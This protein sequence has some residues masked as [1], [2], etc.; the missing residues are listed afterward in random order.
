[1]S[2]WEGGGGGGWK[3]ELNLSLPQGMPKL[4]TSRCGDIS[5][6]LRDMDLTYQIKTNSSQVDFKLCVLLITTHTIPKHRISRA[7][8]L[9]WAKTMSN[10]IQTVH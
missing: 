6:L 2:S 1:M 9:L 3:E 4:E 10:N 7:T 5:I 8:V